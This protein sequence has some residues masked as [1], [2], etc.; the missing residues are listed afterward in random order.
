MENATIKKIKSAIEKG[1]FKWQKIVNRGGVIDY[2]ALNP[3]SILA[4]ILSYGLTTHPEIYAWLDGYVAGVDDFDGNA[5]VGFVHDKTPSSLLAD[6][7]DGWIDDDVR[8]DT[9]GYEIDVEGNI[10]YLLIVREA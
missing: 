6:I 2:T 7:G 5:I 8:L 4:K 3:D 9:E 10:E 1:S